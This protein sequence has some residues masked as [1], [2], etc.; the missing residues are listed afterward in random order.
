MT[1]GRHAVPVIPLAR[2]FEHKLLI[3][4]GA[5]ASAP[6]DPKHVDDARVL[7]GLLGRP[8]PDV[9][10]AAL[11]PDVYGINADEHCGRCELSADP[12]WPLAPRDQICELL[13]WNAGV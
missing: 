9:A 1:I 5:S 8:V 13:G 12:S 11:A 7:G 2:I 4:S 10:E 3:L 6:I